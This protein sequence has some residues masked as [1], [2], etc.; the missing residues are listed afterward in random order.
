MAVSPLRSLRPGVLVLAVARV[1]AGDPVLAHERVEVRTGHAHV[2]GG[3]AHVPLGA[4]A[5]P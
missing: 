4:C 2:A 5:V 1:R 3:L